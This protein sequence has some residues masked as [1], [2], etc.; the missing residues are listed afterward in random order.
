MISQHNLQS[1]CLNP[2]AKTKAVQQPGQ[3]PATIK[4]SKRATMVETVPSD[5]GASEVELIGSEPPKEPDPDDLLIICKVCLVRK[6]D[7]IVLPCTH[8]CLCQQCYDHLALPKECPVCRRM[9]FRNLSV[10]I[11][12]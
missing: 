4:K 11:E 2:A 9:V 12:T 10:I 1:H 7:Q 6:I 3:W 8:A 5:D